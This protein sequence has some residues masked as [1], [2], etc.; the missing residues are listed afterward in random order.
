MGRRSRRGEETQGQDTAYIEVDIIPSSA[1]IMHVGTM[2]NMCIK[3]AQYSLHI[4][5]ERCTPLDMISMCQD[6]PFDGPA[7]RQV[8]KAYTEI[9][10]LSIRIGIALRWGEHNME[11]EGAA[12]SN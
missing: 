11:G 4:S 2:E 9:D 3:Y 10:K 7:T 6:S 8:K 5:V 1:K 12:R